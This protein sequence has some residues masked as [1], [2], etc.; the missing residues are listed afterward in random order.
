M[1]IYT[2]VMNMNDLIIHLNK[3]S[4]EGFEDALNTTKGIALEMGLEPGFPK[5]RLKRRK[6][7]FDEDNEEDDEDKSPEDSF[8]CF[9]F[10]V[11]MD[12]A[13]M[14]LQT[15]FD[16]MKN[17]HRIFGFMFSSRNLKSLA[18]D[19]LKECCEILAD[20][21]QDGEKEDVDRNDLFQEL[22]MLQNVLPDDKENVIQIL[23]FV[24]IMD[25]Y[26]NTTIA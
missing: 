25:C 1:C 7:Y 8:K 24:K 16:Q 13:L 26:P 10:N 5:K 4:E 22:K 21:L 2:C 17:F 14:S 20:A 18:H 11:V 12:A 9:Y 3:Y 15:R 19:K 23:D 6:R